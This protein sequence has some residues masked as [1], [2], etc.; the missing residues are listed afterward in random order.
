VTIEQRGSSA[1]IAPG[2][3]PLPGGGSPARSATVERAMSLVES[4]L[5]RDETD[6]KL[7]ATRA[8]MPP[9]KRLVGVLMGS[10]Q[11]FRDIAEA[12]S[13]LFPMIGSIGFGLLFAVVVY[14]SIDME[15]FVRSQLSYQ[16]EEVIQAHLEAMETNP[17]GHQISLYFGFVVGPPLEVLLCSLVF[18]GLLTLAH[19]E[20]TFKKVF[21]VL[22]HT[23]FAQTFVTC[24]VT[25]AV[26]SIVG[27]AGAWNPE[28]TSLAFLVPE[29]GSKLLTALA[30][31]LDV[32]TFY[33]LY[34]MSLGLTAVTSPA[35]AGRQVRGL[36]GGAWILYVATGLLVKAM[37]S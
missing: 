13:W 4:Q 12:P 20:T 33:H 22:S 11:S 26:L 8:G 36:V 24:A 14:H 19:G 21:A 17:V 15:A 27:D 37:V 34:L 18:L 25:I 6:R 5:L 28:L 23:F 9:W 2:F 1:G 10:K 30:A 3:S 16:P 7:E 29:K 32:V 35:L 31:Q